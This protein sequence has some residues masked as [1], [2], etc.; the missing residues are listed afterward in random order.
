MNISNITNLVNQ[1]L[2]ASKAAYTE[3]IAQIIIEKDNYLNEFS[4]S[5][6]SVRLIYDHV[7]NKIIHITDNAESLGGYP[8]N[9]FYSLGLP[10]LLQIVT[11]EHLDFGYKWWKWSYEIQLKYGASSKSKQAFCGVKLKH[12]DGRIM[13]VLFRQVGIRWDEKGFITVSALTL[14]DVSHLMKADFYWGRIESTEADKQLFHLISTE[15]TYKPSDILTDREKEIIRLLAQGKESKEIATLLFMSSHT[16]DNHRRNMINKIGVR[17][18]T[19]LI[20]ISRMVGI[21]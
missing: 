19:G 10:F 1:L 6:N 8:M 9:N 21:I 13:R 12:K 16:V 11:F 2:G 7:N 18:T 14:D 3:D 15:K 17:D 4:F 5:D 20:Q